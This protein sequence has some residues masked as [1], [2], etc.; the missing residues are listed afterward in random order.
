MKFALTILGS[1]A[2]VPT[3]NRN[4]TAQLL[5][6]REK[7][8]LIDCA[9]GTQLQLT[10]Y[11]ISI[12]KISHIFI[13]HLHGDHYYGLPGLLSKLHLLGRRKKLELYGPPGLEEI[14][15][16]NFKYSKTKLLYPLEFHPLEFDKSYDICT[17]D[18]FTVTT[19]P[20]IHSVPTNGFLFKEQPL[21]R[22]IKKDFVERQNIPIP[23]FEKIKEGKDFI[24]ESGKVFPNEDITFD[25]HPQRSYAYCSDTGYSEELPELIKNVDLI[26][27][28][29]TFAESMR[30]TAH[31]KLHATAKEAA[32]TAKNANA[33]KLLLGHFSAR[34]KEVDE[35]VNEARE[36]FP[37]TYAAKDGK[38]YELRIKNNE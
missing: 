13:S 17:N 12:Q 31:Q 14:L 32:L 21:K 1:G 20:L 28:E 2:A 24:D 7:L 33:G 34:Y 19:L 25:P 10:R 29:A 8:I 5:N 30:E 23:E 36:I 11:G 27:H 18:Q 15:R 26:Y 4:P 3:I 35:L 37:E 6:I 38:T 22:K 9:E 16:I